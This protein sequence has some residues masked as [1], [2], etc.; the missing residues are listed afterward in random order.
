[1][2]R[3]KRRVAHSLFAPFLLLALLVLAG[4]GGRPTPAPTDPE[5]GAREGPETPTPLPEA[6]ATP[7]QAATPSPAPTAS[8]PNA[9]DWSQHAFV[10]EGIFFLGNPQAPIRMVDYSDFL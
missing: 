6:T 1:M 9:Q 7:P 8:G 3:P 10:E 5:A 2:D 4:C